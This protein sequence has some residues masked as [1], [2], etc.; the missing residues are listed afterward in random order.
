M[1]S[2]ST[3]SRTAARPRRVR[4]PLTEARRG[5]WAAAVTLAL[6]GGT[7]LE[8]L[9]HRDN[10]TFSW[11]WLH[12]SLRAFGLLYGGSFA[13]AAGCLL[14]SREVRRGTGEL[15]ASLPASTL[16]RTA[17]A[18]VP[19]VLWPVFGYVLTAAVA[20]TI[21]A[22]HFEP[23]H[24]SPFPTLLFADAVAVGS[25][26]LLGF[27]A[28]RLLPRPLASPVLGGLTGLVLFSLAE[29]DVF[30]FGVGLHDS[31]S[32]LGPAATHWLPWDAPAWWFGPASALWFGGVAAAALL[33]YAAR[34]R[35]A[36]VALAVALTGA[37]VLV[38]T[39]D[40]L[41]RTDPG[42]TALTCADGSPKVCMV[43]VHSSYLPPVS[44][45]LKGVAARLRGIPNAPERLIEVPVAGTGRLVPG[46]HVPRRDEA[47]I[48]TPAV[49]FPDDPSYYAQEAA[50][51]T[52]LYGC[53]KS[54]E[55]YETPI[56]EEYSTAVAAW[57]S[58]DPDGP[59]GPSGKI[60][61]RLEAMSGGERT[62]WLG[63]Y[64]AA[65]RDCRPDRIR[66][67]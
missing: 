41:W 48:G 65:V 54:P 36:V 24:G 49:N 56:P 45:A 57:L 66:A 16:R 50:Y 15:Y 1:P 32:P 42:A 62:A 52:A 53:A 47:A 59:W 25:L 30:P 5:L 31:L 34:R 27:L 40:G 28:G 22:V 20:I 14:G 37:G 17:L 44:R 46:A 2:V 43:S 67:P 55:T 61:R 3:L 19:A 35:L 38:G 7:L 12:D 18:A 63:D 33:A 11:V 26:G 51:R 4:P 29:E 21:T 9:P 13:V 23:P 58:A 6:L 8:L 60:S 64:F 39:A 10:L